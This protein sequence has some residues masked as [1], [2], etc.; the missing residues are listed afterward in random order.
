MK[1]V[2][3]MVFS[4]TTHEPVQITHGEWLLLPRDAMLAQYVQ[5][6]CV[7]PSV[8]PSQAITVSKELNVRSRKQ[9]PTIPDY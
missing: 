6:S 8:R 1:C 2:N 5:S 3:M 4:T 7:R 9:R